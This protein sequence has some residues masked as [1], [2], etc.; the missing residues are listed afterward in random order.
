VKL[1]I[2]YNRDDHKLSTESYSQTYRHMFDALIEHNEWENVQHVTESCHSD[3]IDADIIIIYDIHSSHHIEIED[4]KFHKSIKY[5]YFNDPHQPDVRGQYKDGT[6]VHKLGA[7]ERIVRALQRGI[8]FIICPYTDGYNK[9]IAPSLGEDAELMFVWFPVAPKRL[10]TISGSS[11][12]LIK[13]HHKILAN[14]H[15]WEGWEGFRPYAFRAWAHQRP[16][17]SLVSHCLHSP[18]MYRGNSFHLMLNRFAAA[19]AL[20]DWYVVPKYLEIPLAG[21]LCF[22]QQ[23]KD[24]ER[25]GFKDNEHCIYVNRHNFDKATKSFL[26]DIPFYQFIADNGRKLAENNYTAEHFAQY[27]FNH[28]KEQTDGSSNN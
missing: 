10:S 7:Q 18:H 23:N 11:K 15:T 21:C 17:L 6:L 27:I 4:L 13:R 9:F 1:A 24:Y 12:L 14:G 28:S 22:A 16:Q 26:Q 3:D 20:T 5:T 25:M 8:N 2:V 19:V